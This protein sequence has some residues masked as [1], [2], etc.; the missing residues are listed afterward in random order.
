M[1]FAAIGRPYLVKDVLEL[2]LRE[3]RALHVLHRTQLFCHLFAIFLPHGLHLLL[4]QLLPD[5]RVIS[6][7]RL[8]ADY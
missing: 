2:E 3:S 5:L 7:I 6:Q 8:G 4:C 1:C